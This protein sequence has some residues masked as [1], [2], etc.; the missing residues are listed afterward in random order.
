MF[1]LAVLRLEVAGRVG[2]P[3][4]LV[5]LVYEG[6]FGVDQGALLGEPV[7]LSMSVLLQG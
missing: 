1:V 7:V 3:V 5:Q 4:L 6:L 2:G